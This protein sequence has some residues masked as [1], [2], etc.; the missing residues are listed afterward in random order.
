MLKAVFVGFALL[1]AV[2]S[3]A[4]SSAITPPAAVPVS[5]IQGVMN[6]TLRGPRPTPSRLTVTHQP[7]GRLAPA[8][9]ADGFNAP[10]FAG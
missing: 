4:L 7:L 6:G 10:G 2:P 9:Y 3:T 5:C 1:G 8:T